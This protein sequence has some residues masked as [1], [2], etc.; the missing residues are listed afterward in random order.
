[1]SEPSKAVLITGCSSGIGQATALR[2][3]R[4]GWTVYATARHVESLAP[5]REAGCHSLTLD[6]TDER[7]MRAAVDEIERTEGAVGVL[8]NNAGYSQS[9]AIE[10]VPLDAVRRQFE[11]NIF[12]LVGLTQLVLPKMR[13]QRWGKIVNVGSMGG[14]LSF[15][16]AGHYH[17]TKH[18]LEAISDAL[19]FELR[20]FGIDVIL[21]EPGL[22]TTEFG[23]AAVASMARTQA[24]AS[25]GGEGPYARFN[26]AVG[27]LTAGAYEGPMRV[28]GGGPDRVAKVIE[29]V[30]GR[31]RAP[32]RVAI[33]PSA[34]LM[35]ALHGLVGDRVWDAI[36]RR[37]FPQPE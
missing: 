25:E 17:A 19:R 23:H 20:G 35:I 22:I 1:V 14:R 3:A 27:A 4:S 15:P 24:G 12:G 10:T 33:T 31:R 18:A 16:G 36:M 13:A 2:L 9:G 11:T 8:V 6:V 7:S 5:L 21:L 26:A 29:N 30:L 34:K 37:Q 32:A 28:L